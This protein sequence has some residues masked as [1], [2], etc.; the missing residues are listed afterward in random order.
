[1]DFSKRVSRRQFLSAAASSTAASIVARPALS[2]TFARANYGLIPDVSSGAAILA[3]Q[4][5]GVINTANSPFGK[6]RSVPVHAVAIEDGFWSKRRATNVER[7]IP[8]MRQELE[9]HG[10]MDN[11]RRLVGKS[12]EPQK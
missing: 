1:M 2:A 12:S 3:W 5:Q 10:R 4:D 9:D 11:F 7:S 6:L 8:T